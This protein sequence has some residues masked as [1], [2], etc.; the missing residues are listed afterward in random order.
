MKHKIIIILGFLFF[1]ATTLLAQTEAFQK[2]Q[3]AYGKQ[4]FTEAFKWYSEAANRGSADAMAMLGY[5]YEEGQGVPASEEEAIKWY[6]KAAEKNQPGAFYQLAQIYNHNTPNVTVQTEAFY[7]YKKAAEAGNP[8]AMF[9]IAG[10]YANERDFLKYEKDAFVWYKKAADAGHGE[11]ARIT[12]ENYLRGNGTEKD[13]NRAIEYYEKGFNGGDSRSSFILG[14]LYLEGKEIKQDFSKAT[15]WLEKSEE[16][17]EPDAFF[18]LGYMYENGMGKA[19]DIDKALELYKEAADNGSAKGEDAYARLAKELKKPN[20]NVA[21][22]QQP[23]ADEIS[24]EQQYFEGLK[25]LEENKTQKAIELFES[26]AAKGYVESM[27]ELGSLYDLGMNGLREDKEKAIKWYRMAAQ[28]G[29]VS[30]M[31]YLGIQFNYDPKLQ[32]KDSTIYWY[33]KAAE[34]GDSLSTWDLIKLYTADNTYDNYVEAAKWYKSLADRGDTLAASQYRQI[35]K[36]IQ[37]YEKGLASSSSSGLKPNTDGVYEKNKGMDSEVKKDYSSAVTWYQKASDLGNTMA[38]T[39]LGDLYRDGKGVPKNL[40]QA[41]KWYLKAHQNGYDFAAYLLGN[42]YYKELNKPAEG[43]K[44]LEEYYQNHGNHYDFSTMGY[45]YA[46][47]DERIRNL[48][49]AVYWYQKAYENGETDK[50][51]QIGKLYLNGDKGFRDLDK[52]EYYF[53]RAKNEG[54]D[55]DFLL[56]SLKSAKELAVL[57]KE[58]AQN[59]ALAKTNG[60]AEYHKAFEIEETNPS[61]ALNL[62]KQSAEKGDVRAMFSIYFMYNKGEGVAKNER[63]ALKWLTMAGEKGDSTAI[64]WLARGYESETFG[65]KDIAK[66]MYWYK[67]LSPLDPSGRIDLHIG[68]GYRYNEAIKNPKEAEIWFEKAANKGLP[69]G[70]F[71]LGKVLEGQRE[72]EKAV[73]W[74]KKAG[75]NG[76]ATAWKE[77]GGIYLLPSMKNRELALEYLKKAMGLNV[78]GAKD[79][80]DGAVRISES[81]RQIE[82]AV[83]IM[84]DAYAFIEKKE[85]SSAFPLLKKSAEMGHMGAMHW[86]G[87]LY[88]NGLGTN[89]DL[90]EEV[91]WLTLAANKGHRAALSQLASLYA[92]GK[93]VKKD[94]REALRLYLKV[95]LLDGIYAYSDIF[96]LIRKEGIYLGGEYYGRA[97]QAVNQKDYKTAVNLLEKLT[98]LPNS[99]AFYLLGYMYENGLGVNKDVK[100]AYENYYSGAKLG[101]PKAIQQLKTWLQPN[102]LQRLGL[103]SDEYDEIKEEIQNILSPDYKP[104]FALPEYVNQMLEQSKM[105]DL[106]YEASFLMLN[107]IKE[108]PVEKI[109]FK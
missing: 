91:K 42:L 108:E 23:I 41:E 94:V 28:N 82:Q 4:N 6:K 44:L 49:K 77:L 71:E 92:E 43:M 52:A 39:Q 59:Q 75:E 57:E 90:N 98:K 37:D 36:A 40:Q 102:A 84:K 63:E 35:A 9:R 24:G 66:S 48:G 103:N 87:M 70:M 47:E 10:I 86:L 64:S 100:T 33:Q 3:D 27:V 56:S 93:G 80:Y 13:I 65:A 21:V 34:L 97:Q 30:S 2:G 68:I 51:I 19:K 31:R 46:Y 54:L 38:M 25:F 104:N 67:K 58:Q 89:K 55:V 29:D 12:A 72:Y 62:Y 53:N 20:Q 79:L 18:A 106:A 15:Y 99:D 14:A 61:E 60:E 26:S 22:T 5:M 50:L 16:K 85:Y 74:Y 105:D 83:S 11:A 88:G 109:F 107:R 101:N 76:E 96:E 78:A 32:N 7:W 73:A 69:E 1:S 17:G 81:S 45:R 8:G 95:V